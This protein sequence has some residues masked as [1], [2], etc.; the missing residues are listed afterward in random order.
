MVGKILVNSGREIFVNRL[1]KT[2]VKLRWEILVNRGKENL[3]NRG[4]NFS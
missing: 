2:L 1:K 3:V 4:R